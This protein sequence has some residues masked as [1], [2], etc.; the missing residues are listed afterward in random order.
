MKKEDTL[1]TYALDDG[2][3]DTKFDSKGEPEHIP[4]F[5][6]SFRPKPKEDFGKDNKL[7]YVAIEIEG[8][9]YVVGDYATKLDPDIRWNAADHKH[10]TDNFD[11][12]LKTSLGLMCSGNKEVINM[13]MMN[14]P[15]NFDTPE[16]RFDLIQR[17]VRTH[18]FRISTDGVHFFDKVV[19]IENLDIKK[20]PFGSLCD[21]ILDH[22]GDMIDMEVAKGFNVLV[23]IGSRTLNILT[24]DA[25][26]EQESLSLQDN[27]GMF[28]SYIQIGRFLEQEFKATIPN[29]K[30][31][32]IIKNREIRGRDIS[33]IVD[34]VFRDHADSIISTLHT[35]LLDSWAFVDNIVFT[36]GGAEVLQPYLR[37]ALDK[38]NVKFLGRYS[39]VSGLRKYGVRKSKK[40]ARGAR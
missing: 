38:V 13:L 2:Y 10:N 16:R 21:I 32:S 5:V 30:L 17:V 37:D 22:N 28:K 7:K 25:L 12:L 29:G 27:Q 20:Q 23:D 4:S 34:R 40:P 9:R 19:N 1:T 15:L 31:P 8:Q 33:P 26:E 3:G 11:V 14:L 6:T 24:V 18:D 36:G 35:I 39:N